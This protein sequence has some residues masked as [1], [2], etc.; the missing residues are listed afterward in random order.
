M[1]TT[2]KNM[3][4]AGTRVGLVIQAFRNLG[5][6]NIDDVAQARTQKFL[7]GTSKNELIKNLKYAPQWVR[8]LIFSIMDG[9]YD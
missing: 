7:S 9:T 8:V 2:E 6:D 3:R 1:T 4:S 5:K